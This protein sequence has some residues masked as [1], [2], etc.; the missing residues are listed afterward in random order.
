MS[1]GSGIR[2]RWGK[3]FDRGNRAGVDFSVSPVH[4]VVDDVEVT[5]GGGGTPAVD[6]VVTGIT[7]EYSSSELVLTQSGDS[8]VVEA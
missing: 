4:E 5:P 2:P 8:I 6:V 1:F 3:L 7:A